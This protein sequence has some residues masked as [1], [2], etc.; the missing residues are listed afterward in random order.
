MDVA[1][2]PRRAVDT[3]PR[4]LQPSRKTHTRCGRDNLFSD[5][6]EGRYQSTT[7][8]FGG[9]EETHT[10]KLAQAPT[11]ATVQSEL[12]V[13]RDRLHTRGR[14]RRRESL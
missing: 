9:E 4:T 7:E 3:S 12:C 8:R 14:D 5:N 6:S 2:A 10:L 13:Q 1:P 11:S